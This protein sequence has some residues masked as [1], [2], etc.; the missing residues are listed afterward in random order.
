MKVI[1][2]TYYM[3]KYL[4]ED[5]TKFNTE[6]DCK[7]YEDCIKWQ[8]QQARLQSLCENI[9]STGCNGSIR[10]A[11]FI[12]DNYDKI[13]EIMEGKTEA[14]PTVS[15]EVNWSEV[16]AGTAILVRDR[17]RDEWVEYVFIDY[18]ENDNYPYRCAYSERGTVH[19]I[20]WKF[21]KLKP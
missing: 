20:S 10:L 14:K 9:S 5:G 2:E 7:Q 12:I 8:D 17:E 21:A 19:P 15:P 6:A 3:T 11:E 13:K 16:P 4:A 18:K 1:T